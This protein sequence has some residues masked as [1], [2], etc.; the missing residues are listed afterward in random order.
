AAPIIMLTAKDQEDDRVRG[1]ELGADDYVTKPFS[2]RELLARIGAVLRRSHPDGGETLVSGALH[3]D[4]KRRKVTEGDR[5][6]ELT[7]KEFDLLALLMSHPGEPM[8]RERLLEEVWG[9][10]FAGGT[11]TLDVHVRRLRQKI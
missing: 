8:G 5:E 9:Y 3:L 10:E 2:P 4:L 1:F 11:R 7:P 6:I